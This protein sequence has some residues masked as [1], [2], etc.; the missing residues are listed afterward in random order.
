[1]NIFIKTGL[2]ISNDLMNTYDPEICSEKTNKF[3][4]DQQWVVLLWLIEKI[5]DKRLDDSL[6]YEFDLGYNK[7]IDEILELLEEKQ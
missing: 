3:Y 4:E 5:K 7:A 6:E 2:Q 1:M